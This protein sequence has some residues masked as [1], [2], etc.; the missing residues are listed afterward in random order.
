MRGFLTDPTAPAGLRL[1][2]ALPEPEPAD[3]EFLMAVHAY[4]LNRDELNLIRRRPDGWRPGQDV[5]GTVLRAAAAGTGPA[6]GTRVLARLEE[7][8]W[9]ERAAVP[10]HS[11]AV[12]EDAVTFA[13]AATLPIAGI[14]ALRALR[15]GG[16]LLGADVL[17]T[18]ATGGV[19]QFAVQLAAAAGA[20][21]T[22]H[23]SR[24]ERAGAALALG[25]RHTVTTLAEAAPHGPYQLV[26]DGIGGPVL[27]DAVRLLAPGAT[28]VLY[29]NVAGPSQLSI[30][31]FYAQGWNARLV[32]LISADPTPG[33][34]GGEAGPG[35]AADL[36]TL[37]RLVADGRLTP[38]TTLTADWTRTPDA[39]T[40]LA[41][42]D[43][44]GKA[45]LTLPPA[46][47]DP[48]LDPA[49]DRRL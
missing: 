35:M 21:V 24:P 18:G 1:T 38:H 20:R 43:I 47:T 2:G 31:D 16:P 41:R 7:L 6:A 13:Q 28:A 8:G 48:A 30:G 10:V 3:G 22:A 42:R 26:L 37:V 4:A 27:T 45:V 29:G 5:A 11:A 44:R 9:A 25:A 46:A 14:T 40:A 32:G 19:G 39:L 17:V 33:A 49:L 23:V 15:Q 12:L 34:T 36:A